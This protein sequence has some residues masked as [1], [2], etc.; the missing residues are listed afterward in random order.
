MGVSMMSN[1]PFSRAAA[2][3]TFS[4][5]SAAPPPAPLPA[6]AALWAC[7]AMYR[8]ADTDWRYSAPACTTC[9]YEALAM[10]ETY[11]HMVLDARHCTACAGA[12]A[13]ARVRRP[14]GGACQH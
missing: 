10:V 2:F 12:C 4:A 6:C 14:G 8:I 3:R 7:S 11:V 1:R 9:A 5:A 13:A